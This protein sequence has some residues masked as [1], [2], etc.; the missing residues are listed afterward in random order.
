[1]DKIRRAAQVVEA[2]KTLGVLK[3]D[4]VNCYPGLEKGIMVAVQVPK[5]DINKYNMV[6]YAF[7][8]EFGNWVQVI[9]DSEVLQFLIY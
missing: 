2:L 8:Q 6:K 7:E 9:E 3:G 4:E 1:M 5:S